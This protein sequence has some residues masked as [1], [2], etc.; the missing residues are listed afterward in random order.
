MAHIVLADDGIEFDGESPAQGPLGGVESSI[1]NLTR[2]LAVRGH[3][4][5]VH[6]MCAA[7]KVIK[8]VSWNPLS[9]GLPETADLYIANRGDKLLPLMPAARRTVFWLPNREP[10]QN[11]FRSRHASAV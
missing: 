7:S 2:A 9:E 11:C 10:F 5:S 8:G 4:V 6:N 1:V 3:D